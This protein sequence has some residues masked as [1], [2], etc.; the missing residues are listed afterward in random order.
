MPTFSD[1]ITPDEADATYER[2]VRI[3][4]S[5]GPSGAITF[6]DADWEASLDGAYDGFDLTGPIFGDLYGYIGE[7]VDTS[8]VLLQV[9]ELTWAWTYPPVVPGLPPGAIDF[10]LEDPSGLPTSAATY[11][12]TYRMGIASVDGSAEL[13]ASIRQVATPGVDWYTPTE[14]G[15]LTEL[16][17]WAHYDTATFGASIQDLTFSFDHANDDLAWLIVLGVILAE[18]DPGRGF[19][20]NL[21]FEPAGLPVGSR[22]YQP[23]RYRWVYPDGPWPLRQRQRPV[24]ALEVRQGAPRGMVARQDRRW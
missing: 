19:G 13:P 23:P 24:R 5:R 12:G 9:G 3:L 15:A 7:A 2:T 6:D 18:G 17:S 11:S 10:E 16:D 4:D 21:N 1:W 22:T 20:G 8:Q 14:L